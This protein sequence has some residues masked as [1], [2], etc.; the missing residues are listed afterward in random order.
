MQSRAYKQ[1]VYEACREK[2]GPSY[3]SAQNFMDAQDLKRGVSTED[4]PAARHS[5]YWDH[6]DEALA[7]L[8][9][10]R[11]MF[12]YVRSVH[13][14]I[15]GVHAGGDEN[16]VYVITSGQ[17]HAMIAPIQV[18]GA[19]GGSAFPIFTITRTVGL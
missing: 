16:M 17:Q 5:I 14:C 13:V 11:E 1:A 9:K 18:R 15:D 10:G 2:P 19:E 4:L 7:Y 3:A 12:R 6:R 8:S